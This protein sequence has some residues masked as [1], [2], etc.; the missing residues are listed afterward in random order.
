M[1][2][3]SWAR[4]DPTGYEVSSKGDAHFSAFHAMM[5]DGRTIEHW[6]QCDV[7]GY[8]PGS[9]DWK[10]GKGKPSLVPYTGDSQWQ[11]YLALWRIWGVHH[12]HLFLE[13]REKLGS[14]RVLTDSFATTPINQAHALAVLLNEWKDL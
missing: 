14:N 5:P 3:Y 7:K 2:L 1:T 8:A 9:R 4:H 12:T 10:Q 13:L 11:M 6:Y